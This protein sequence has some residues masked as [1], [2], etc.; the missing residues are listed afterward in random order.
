MGLP[1][2]ADVKAIETKAQQVTEDAL[3]NTIALRWRLSPL[4]RSDVSIPAERPDDWDAIAEVVDSAFDL[5]PRL[6][7]SMPSAPLP[8]SCRSCHWPPRAQDGSSAT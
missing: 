7:S 8:T 1:S 3:H 6:G 4:S 2:D 5:R